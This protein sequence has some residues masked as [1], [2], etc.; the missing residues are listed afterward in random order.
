[1]FV[2]EREVSPLVVMLVSLTA[3]TQFSTATVSVRRSALEDAWVEVNV[4][5]VSANAEVASRVR[6]AP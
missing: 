3:L 6:I 2:L 4:S 5:T 1:M